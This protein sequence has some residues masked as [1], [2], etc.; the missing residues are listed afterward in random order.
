[1]APG[2]PDPVGRYRGAYFSLVA[3]PA[4]GEY[5]RAGDEALTVPLAAAD[6]AI[7]IIEPSAA[8]GEPVLLLP[9]GA[10]E[11][12]EPPARTANRELQEEAGFEG[13]RL[14]FL[15]ALRPF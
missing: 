9:G 15:A 2:L 10:V 6:E 5:V 8:F 14:D 13:G 12:G 4:A 11:P 3:D 1:M 7:L